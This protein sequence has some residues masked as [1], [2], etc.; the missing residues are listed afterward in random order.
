MHMRLVCC[1]S[2]CAVA[3]SAHCWGPG[4]MCHA[5]SLMLLP[6]CWLHKPCS[7]CVCASL[8]SFG[9]STDLTL[10]ACIQLDGVSMLPAFS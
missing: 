8:Q 3:H 6:A 5:A 9:V 10:L 2:L 4:L 7:P 1:G